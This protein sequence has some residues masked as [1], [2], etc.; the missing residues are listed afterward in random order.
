MMRFVPAATPVDVK[1]SAP[2]IGPTSQAGKTR[3]MAETT[4]LVDCIGLLTT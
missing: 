3:A 4:S 2:R 1:P